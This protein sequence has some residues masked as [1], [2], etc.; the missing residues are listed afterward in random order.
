MMPQS[1]EIAT[2]GG[3]VNE[4]GRGD[5]NLRTKSTR[6]YVNVRAC[7]RGGGGGAWRVLGEGGHQAVLHQLESHML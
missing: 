3:G 5:P 4:W 2:R 7:L 1:G 6:Q